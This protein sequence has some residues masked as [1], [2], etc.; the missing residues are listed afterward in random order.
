MT[1]NHKSLLEPPT[2]TLDENTLF[3]LLKSPRCRVAVRTMK[4]Y[5][6]VTLEAGELADE[7]SDIRGVNRQTCYVSL[8]QTHLP[9]L[10]NAGVIDYDE[11]TK[12]IHIGDDVTALAWFAD[13]GQTATTTRGSVTPSSP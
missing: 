9:K 11:T 3:D 7:V 5:P 1:P 12:Q 6:G 2:T 13:R 4:N 10:N 8:I